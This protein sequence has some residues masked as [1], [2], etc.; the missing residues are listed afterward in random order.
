M[1]EFPCCTCG[2]MLPIRAL[3]CKG[4][5]R[6]VRCKE[7]GDLLEPEARACVSCGALVGVSDRAVQD[8]GSL[9]PSGR[10]LNVLEFEESAKHRRLRTEFTDEAVKSLA[11][12]V[13]MFIGIRLAAPPRRTGP[14]EGRSV[15]GEQ[16]ALP[17]TTLA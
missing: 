12:P 3:F 11:G 9:A 13:G 15:P 6:Q 10:T 7:C 2:T 16:L 5:A 8:G 4:C 17:I 1:S 14:L